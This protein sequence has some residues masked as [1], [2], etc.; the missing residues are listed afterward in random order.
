[1]PKFDYVHCL[2]LLLSQ[3]IN[4]KVKDPVK[5][6]QEIDNLHGKYMTKMVTFTVL[7]MV[8]FDNL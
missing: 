8:Y 4:K 3:D 2:A 7:N 1:M 6:Q 5:R